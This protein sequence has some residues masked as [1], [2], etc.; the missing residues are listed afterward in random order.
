M[1]DNKHP[2]GNMSILVNAPRTGPAHARRRAQREDAMSR[3]RPFRILGVQQIAIG[4][5]SKAALRHLWV[6]LF[7][8]AAD[9]H[10]PQRA[11]ERRRGH[12]VDRRRR[13]RSDG[14]DRSRRRSP[15]CTSRGS[16]TSACGSTTCRPRSRGSSEQ[17]VRFT[18]GGIRKGAAGH[19]VCF[20]HPKG[21]PRRGRADRARAGAARRHRRRPLTAPRGPLSSSSVIA[22]A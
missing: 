8:I 11:R 15:R 22:R 2:S 21:R 7:G 6:D 1:R 9:R 10:V 19:D 17:G 18:P 5:P 20:I 12:P 13:D 16:T 4:G 3:P 14:A